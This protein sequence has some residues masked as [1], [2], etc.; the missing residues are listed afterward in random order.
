MKFGKIFLAAFLAVLC[1]SVAS[2]FIIFFVGAGALTSFGLKSIITEPNSVL[3]INFEEDI[4]DSPISSPVSSVDI[5]NMN[6]VQPITLRQTLTAIENAAKD[7]AIK[8]I[9]IRPDGMGSASLSNME[10]LRVALEK[11]KESGKFIVAYCD[12]YTQF[13]YY[14]ATVA[15]EILL[16]PEGNLDWKGV[17][18]ST[19][20]YKGLI[21]KL[22]ADVEIFRPTVC[23]YKSAV[24]PFFLKKMSPENRKQMEVIVNSVWQTVCED[25]AKSRNLNIEDLKNYAAN[26]DIACGEDAVRY[27]LIDRLA[28]EDELYALFDSYGVERNKCGHHNSV[29]LSEY[30]NA[31]I[32]SVATVTTDSNFGLEL[33]DNKSL[34]A[35]IYAEGEIVDG[36]EYVAGQ[37]NGTSL[38]REIRQARLDERTKAVVVRVN[39]PGGSALASDIIW[40]EMYLL[41]QTKPVVI[42]MGGSAASGGYY[43][44]APA[45]LIIADKTTLTGS[46]GVFGMML[47]LGNTLSEK[48]GVTMDNASTSE[49]AVTPSLFGGF[50]KAQREVMMKGVDQVYTTFTSKVAD[51]RNL[52]IEHVYDIAEGRVW[53]GRDAV[54]IGLVDRNGGFTDAIA[55]AA[56]L[57]DLGDDFVIYEFVSPLTPFEE[58]V[59]SLGM[60]V[61]NSLGL[62]YS[63][64]GEDIENIVYSSHELI[65]MQGV[66]AR[67][68][69]NLKIEM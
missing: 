53:T 62:D 24:E 21:D 7:P 19:M 20:F 38:A 43:I 12:N 45:D 39:S 27:G 3:Y 6:Y 35:V 28:Y 2:I 41:Q 33:V 49:N 30:I 51:G 56:N 25:V 18:L 54:E 68:V 66:Q 8:G 5:M 34:V 23:R 17:S 44:S 26:L 9:C 67:C 11:F 4:V 50:T 46:I 42:S 10:E 60:F 29:T 40:R 58:W 63:I 61:S 47:N 64:Y 32:F 52:S 69:G 22:G 37:I 65:N 59:N 15:D 55:A 13:S 16:Q 48:L 14:I 31:N 36:D 57:A 1:A